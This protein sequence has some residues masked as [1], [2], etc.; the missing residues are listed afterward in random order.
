MSVLGLHKLIRSRRVE[1][2]CESISMKSWSITCQQEDGEFELVN[3]QI[4][5][6]N[7]I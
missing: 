2:I 1:S 4:I 7:L 3:Q 6:H 5:S